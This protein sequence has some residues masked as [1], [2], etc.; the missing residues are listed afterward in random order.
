MKR[1][2]EEKIDTHIILGNHDTYYKNTN[3]VNAITELC[4][5]Y[6]G[7][8]EPWVYAGP[9]TVNLGG[10]DILFLPWICDQNY[11]ESMYEIENSNAE[12]CMGHLEIKGFEMH[13]GFMN[14]HGLDKTAFHRFEKVMSGHFHKKSDDGQIYYLGTQYEIVWSDYKD[15]KGFHI[16]D[17]DT[18]E[19]T[20]VSNPLRIFRKIYYNDMMEDYDK[21]DISRFDKSFIKLF[22]TNKTDEDMFNRF[23]QRIYDTLTVYQLDIFEDTQDVNTSVPEIEQGEDTTTFLN[24][25]IDHIE[26][27]LDKNK[28]KEKVK[29]LY[30]EASE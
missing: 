26:T 23:V 13:K 29:E 30:Q 25:Y 21:V 12:I 15:P 10:L 8:N 20:R 9:K 1:L 17:T 11:E 4:T 16:F 27:D 22:I 2:W 28:I 6:D 19:L 3:E 24:N 18:R 5:T 14:E 7:V